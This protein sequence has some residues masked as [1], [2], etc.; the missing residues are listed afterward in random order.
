MCRQSG[1]GCL[2]LPHPH[3]YLDLH[4]VNLCP[5]SVHHSLPVLEQQLLHLCSGLEALHLLH[6]QVGQE[7]GGNTTKHAWGYTHHMSTVQLTQGPHLRTDRL[8]NMHTYAHTHTCTHGTHTHI[9][10][11]ITHYHLRNPTL[12]HVKL[13]QERHNLR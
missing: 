2:K 5:Q 12:A 9:T 3:L 13:K 10:H 7:R 1:C 6:T 4:L 11:T 8:R